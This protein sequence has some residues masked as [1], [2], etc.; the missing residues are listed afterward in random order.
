MM[1]FK[2]FFTEAVSLSIT[3]KECK[4]L[5]DILNKWSVDISDVSSK[6]MSFVRQF[7]H[8]FSYTGL[9]H[10]VLWL[11]PYKELEQKEIN[12]INTKQDIMSYERL[13]AE[14]SWSKSLQKVKTFAHEF[15]QSD[16]QFSD[17]EDKE[18]QQL[19]TVLCKQNGTGFDIQT[20]YKA[21]NKR[22]G[23]TSPPPDAIS[24]SADIQEILAPIDDA[25][26]EAKPAKMIFDQPGAINRSGKPVVGGGGPKYIEPHL[27]PKV[28]Y[29]NGD[30]RK[31]KPLWVDISTGK[32]YKGEPTFD[33]AEIMSIYPFAPGTWTGAV[34]NIGPERFYNFKDFKYQPG[35]P[36]ADA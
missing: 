33:T 22:F 26:F 2:K 7:Q 28:Y 4:Q 5:Y 36:V 19:I 23:I 30:Y 14:H 17:A 27:R 11:T 6:E 9:M 24:K 8:L 10:R 21:Y 20:F 15:L 29:A 34:G 31:G 35:D 32:K 1:S 13:H 12:Q 25:S 3:D 18:I 16:F